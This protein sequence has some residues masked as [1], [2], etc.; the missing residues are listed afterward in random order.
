MIK[1][2][3]VVYLEAKKEFYQFFQ[4]KYYDAMKFA[5]DISN[6]IKECKLKYYSKDHDGIHLSYIYNSNNTS[7]SDIS[8]IM[9]IYLLDFYT[10]YTQNTDILEYISIPNNI[11]KLYKLIILDKNKFSIII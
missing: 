7:I 9:H 3:E 2:D 6:N 4:M 1:N 10:K 8:D 5:N 11:E